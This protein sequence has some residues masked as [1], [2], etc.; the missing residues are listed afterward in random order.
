MELMSLDPLSVR[1]GDDG[2][3]GMYIALCLDEGKNV[4]FSF[5]LTE[6]AKKMYM[7]IYKQYLVIVGSLTGEAN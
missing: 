1:E 2:G 3:L 5:G 4:A 6:W 7:C